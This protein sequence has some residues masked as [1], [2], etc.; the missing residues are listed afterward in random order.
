[1]G[2]FMLALGSSEAVAQDYTK[3]NVSAAVQSLD[4]NAAVAPLG[5]AVAPAAT[6][7]S[8]AVATTTAVTLGN[9]SVVQA[10]PARSVTLQLAPSIATE[11]NWLYKAGWP[12]Y[13]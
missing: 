3:L 7:I 10:Q 2:I 1:M 4:V 8:K 5:N 12:L 9:G 13:A 11:A 6:L